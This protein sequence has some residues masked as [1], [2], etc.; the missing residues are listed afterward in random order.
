[1]PWGLIGWSWLEQEAV[2]EEAQASAWVNGE[3]EERDV[4]CVY[5]CIGT[6]VS[7]L[8]YF[9]SGSPVNLLSLF[10]TWVARVNRSVV[11]RQ[12]WGRHDGNINGQVGVRLRVSRRSLRLENDVNTGWPI[13]RVQ[14]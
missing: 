9:M 10:S 3:R 6:M 13:S 12:F 11:S 7:A 5:V 1:M 4:G 2:C 14:V 8:E